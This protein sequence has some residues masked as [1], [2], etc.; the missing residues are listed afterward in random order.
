[1]EPLRNIFCGEGV[2]EKEKER[3]LR[4]KREK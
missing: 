3:D 1:M 2:E 4:R